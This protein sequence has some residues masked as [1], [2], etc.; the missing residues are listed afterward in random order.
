MSQKCEQCDVVVYRRKFIVER[1]LWLGVDCGCVA[2]DRIP[3]T[4]VNCFDLTLDHVHDSFGHKLHVGSIRELSVAEKQYG[5][6][7]V[8]LNSNAQNFDDPPQQRQVTVSDL[9]KRKFSQV[10]QRYA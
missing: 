7:S 10:R 8:V 5:F 6:Q 3:K 1:K 9:V 2:A 4:T